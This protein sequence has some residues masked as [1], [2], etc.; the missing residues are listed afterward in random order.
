MAINSTTLAQSDI[1]EREAMLNC[2]QLLSRRQQHQSSSSG[3][4]AMTSPSSSSSD[5]LFSCKTCHRKFASF[6][7]LGGHSAS[8]NKQLQ[9]QQD[10]SSSQI[11]GTRAKAARSHR[12]SICG[13]EFPMGQALGGHMRR[14]K[15]DPSSVD[16]AIAAA[17]ISTSDSESLGDPTA[18]PNA[19]ALKR[20]RAEEHD[21][22]VDDHKMDS[23]S[24]KLKF[25]DPSLGLSLS[26][27]LGTSTPRKLV[28]KTKDHD[29]LELR[30]GPPVV[31]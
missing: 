24:K 10:D 7:A 19:D 2:M 6:Q 23:L 28:K 21:Q 17:T 30:L 27:S 25:S 22:L 20:L 14:H 4:T 29:F 3:G 8:H 1:V 15:R 16:A 11:T 5:R 12:C 31:Y 18:S 26:L 13:V 9:Q